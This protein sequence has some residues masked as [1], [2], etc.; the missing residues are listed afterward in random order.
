MYT[1]LFHRRIQFPL[2]FQTSCALCKIVLSFPFDLRTRKQ[3]AST[4]C[5]PRAIRKTILTLVT[6]RQTQA[7]IFL[8]TRARRRN[9]SH[10]SLPTR[11]LPQL[12]GFILPT[13]FWGNRMDSMPAFNRHPNC[14]V[15]SK[16]LWFYDS[17]YENPIPLPLTC[18]WLS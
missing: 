16:I 3:R 17:D 13:F 11:H 15:V 12:L 6:T 2:R 5:S 9:A 18:L 14:T 4:V 10:H 7:T 8:E 1:T